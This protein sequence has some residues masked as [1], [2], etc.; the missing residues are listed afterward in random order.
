M[1]LVSPRVLGVDAETG[2]DVQRRRMRL[3]LSIKDLAER[4]GIDRGSLSALEKGTSTVRLSTVGSVLR[5]LEDLEAEYGYDDEEPQPEDSAGSDLVEFE[6][7][8]N[9]GVRVVVKGP[10]RDRAELEES[11]LRLISRMQQAE[12]SQES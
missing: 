1:A 3:G 6:V 11:V 4:A 9:F 10:V 2:N 8:G 7:A 12:Q 5:A